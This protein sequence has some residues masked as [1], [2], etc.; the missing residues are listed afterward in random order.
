MAVCGGIRRLPASGFTMETTRKR[1]LL[2]CVALSFT[3]LFWAGN[4]VV[5]RAVSVD[6][7]PMAL[8]FWRWVVAF[9]VLLPFAWPHLR[10]ALPIA[11]RHWRL[12]TLLAFLSA[13]IFNTLLYLAAQV[14]TAVNI[15]LVNSTMPIFIAIIAFLMTGARLSRPQVLG[16]GTALAG[17]L[18]IIGRGSLDVLL[19]IG[20]NPGDL[21]MVV[22]VACWG[23]YS[24]LLKRMNVN[25]HPLA[26]ITVIIGLALPMV[27]VFYLGELGLGYRMDV[28]I[29]A[30][31]AIAYVGIFPS[32][33]SYMGWN[34]G[35]AVLGPSRASMFVYLIPVLGAIL[36]LVFLGERLHG[37]HWAGALLILLGLYLASL[38]G[39]ATRTPDT[40][41]PRP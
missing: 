29:E 22:A 34:H 25:I 19:S 40:E 35:V 28:G 41:T 6:V 7:P 15:T 16:I 3:S 2:A 39:A 30:L 20:I 38:A 1:E 4:A 8:S 13:G 37:Y 10:V 17:T 32:V 14:T 26:L 21:L 27:F 33:L 36:A 11:R 12:M 24:V 18:V 5:A 31:M 23:V 9:L